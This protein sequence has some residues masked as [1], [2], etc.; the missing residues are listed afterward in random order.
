MVILQK[1]I[2]GAKY[3]RGLIPP[4]KK[5]SPKSIQ[6]A[7]D[8]MMLCIILQDDDDN[9]NV[10]YFNWDGKR[11]KLNFNWADNKFNRND[12]FLRRRYYL[13]AP[14][15]VGAS[16]ISCCFCQPPSIFPTSIRGEEIAIYLLLS[17]AFSSQDSCRKNFRVSSLMLALAMT[18]ILFSLANP[19]VRISS[20]T[21]VK[22]RLIFS[23]REYLVSLGRCGSRLC[24]SL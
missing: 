18:A 10:A 13:L 3:W 19:A 22:S 12:P 23:P 20:T 2:L 4:N 5:Y 15:S 16:F 6:G 14:T 8:Q 24:Q 7:V 11:W 1:K 17:I 21:S 9:G